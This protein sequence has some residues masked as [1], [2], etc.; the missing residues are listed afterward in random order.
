[1]G[2]FFDDPKPRV[3]PLEWKKIRNNLYSIYHF[4]TKELDEVEEIFRGDMNEE[5]E[6]E[7]GIDADELIKGI[8]YMKTHMSLHRISQQ[9]IDALEKEMM[10]KITSS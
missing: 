6:K 4:T 1:M 5:R 3:S 7:K 8:E 2:I 9:K 10:K